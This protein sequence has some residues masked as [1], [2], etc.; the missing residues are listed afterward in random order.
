MSWDRFG[1]ICRKAN[2]TLDA[3]T[4]VSERISTIEKEDACQLYGDAL[5]NRGLTRQILERIGS[6]TDKDQSKK[7]LSVYSQLKVSQYFSEPMQLKRVTIYLAY[8]TFVFFFI[9]SIYQLKVAPAFLDTYALLETPVP[10]HLAFYRDYWL[11]FV[12]AVFCLL[13]LALVIGFTL[14][15][16]LT[17]KVGRENGFIM[18]YLVFRSI[19]QSY[20]NLLELL[21]F[22]VSSSEETDNQAGDISSHL[23]NIQNA[24][25]DLSVELQVLIKKE[26]TIL[27]SKCE[28]QMRLISVLT[29]III[30]ASIFFF[31]SSAYSPLFILGDSI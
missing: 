30:V 20:L 15:N 16:T 14:K 25:M 27:L 28:K 19:R 17:F 7:A 23:K 22:P 21:V 13:F 10:K 29:A 1:Y 2:K 12:F 4:S 3:D 31:L 24:D 18:R 9:S 6:I 8:V 26:V 5:D 11:F